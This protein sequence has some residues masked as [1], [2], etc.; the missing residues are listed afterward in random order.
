MELPAFDSPP[1]VNNDAEGGTMGL[2]FLADVVGNLD[3]STEQVLTQLRIVATR[4]TVE[5]LGN[6]ARMELD[7]YGEDDELPPHRR[8]SL[9]IVGSYH[10]PMQGLIQNVHISHTAIAK[11][12][13]GRVTIHRCRTGVGEI[14]ALLSDHDGGSPLGVEHPNL[15]ELIN[16]G[17]THSPG[18]LCVQARAEFSPVHLRTIVSKARQS[19]LTFCLECE[20]KGVPLLYEA[21][22]GATSEER[23]AWLQTLKLEATKLMM[24]DVWG[25]VW[26]LFAGGG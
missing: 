1:S 26:R 19:A 4:A 6:W 25:S 15:A 21:N 17:P 20:K 24:K 5:D 9:S 2:L 12:A 10:N 8:W 22:D 13:R 23:G 3:V 7:G 11:D 18:W 14:E 16:R